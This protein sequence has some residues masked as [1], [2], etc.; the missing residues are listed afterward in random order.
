MGIRKRPCSTRCR[1]AP[2]VVALLA[3]VALARHGRAQ[4]T[5][6]P[7]DE[8]HP[9][10]PPAAAGAASALTPPPAS[11]EGTELEAAIAGTVNADEAS[12]E[13]D[14]TSAQVD[15]TSEAIDLAYLEV[16]RQPIGAVDAV[17]QVDSSPWAHASDQ[18]VLPSGAVEVGGEVV[19]ITSAYELGSDRIDLTDLGLLRLRV[20]RALGR[21][22]GLFAATTL[23]TKQPQSVDEPL[24]QGVV[25]GLVIPF[26]RWFAAEIAGGGGPLLGCDG[27]HYE[28][29]SG[30][31]FKKPIKRWLRFELGAGTATAGLH[32]RPRPEA[33]FWFEELATHA[34]VQLGEEDEGGAWVGVDYRIP[35]AKSP[36]RP[37]WDGVGQ[38]ALDVGNTLSVTLGTVLEVRDTGWELFALLAIVDRG[39]LEDPST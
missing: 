19:L 12:T 32:L 31:R 18:F 7:D 8:P 38:R 5:T 35:Y 1:G 4:P 28:L 33:P 3:F 27:A 9:G 17:Q 37:V 36:T 22:L 21:R 10:V 23:L 15:E 30:L 14:P 11:A 13:P 26:G 39:E 20:R 16:G 2:L 29:S 6:G 24:W 34:E 25:G